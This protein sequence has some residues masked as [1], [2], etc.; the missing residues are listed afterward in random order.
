ME[1]GRELISVGFNWLMDGERRGSEALPD[2]ADDSELREKAK[3]KRFE[4]E[5]ALM[6]HKHDPQE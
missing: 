4:I 3:I 6:L 1:S 2:V 5:N